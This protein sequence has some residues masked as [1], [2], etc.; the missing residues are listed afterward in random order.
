MEL[1]KCDKCEKMTD[2]FFSFEIHTPVVYSCPTNQMRICSQ[3]FRRMWNSFP[4]GEKGV[5]YDEGILNRIK[6]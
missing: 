5:N 3:C 6:E 1:I 2:K 4:S